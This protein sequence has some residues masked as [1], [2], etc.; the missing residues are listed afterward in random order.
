MLVLCVHTGPKAYE[1]S[2]RNDTV[3]K[4][5]QRKGTLNASV[6]NIMLTAFNLNDGKP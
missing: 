5:K 6:R 1:Q 4:A 3:E 2:E